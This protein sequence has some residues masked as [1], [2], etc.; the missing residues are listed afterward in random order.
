MRLEYRKIKRYRICMT[1]SINGLFFLALDVDI[2]HKVYLVF[3]FTIR[4]LDPLRLGFLDIRG[5]PTE[6]HPAFTF[7]CGII[8]GK[9]GPAQGLTSQSTSVR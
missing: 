4:S 6:N 3:S 5:V 2:D 7:R 8:G 9:N 1:A